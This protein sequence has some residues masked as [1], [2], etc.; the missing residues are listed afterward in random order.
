MIKVVFLFVLIFQGTFLFS[1]EGKTL[2]ATRISNAPNIDGLLNDA[3]WESLPYFGNFNMLK[4]GTDGDIPI[5]YE[6]KVQVAYDDTGLY[7]AAYMNDPFPEKIASQFSQRDDLSAQADF[8]AVTLNTYNDGINET[9]FGVTSSGTIF[10]SK[11]SINDEDLG[12]NVVF[13]GKTSRDDKGWYAEFK[14]PYNALRFPEVDI[15]NWSINFY[16]RIINT[17]ETHS[18]API[19]NTKGRSTIYN[20]PLVGVKDINPPVRLTLFPFAQGVVSS[21]EGDTSSNF[22]AGMDLKYGLSDS[23]T[24]DATLV[25]D[26]G[27]AAF[28]EVTLN[29]GPFEQTFDEQRQFFIEGTEL[30]NKGRIFFSRRVGGAPSETEIDLDENEVVTILP[31]SV[32]LLNAIKVSGRTKDNLGVGF[33]NVITEKTTASVKNEETGSIRNVLVEPLTNYSI[34]VLDQQFNNN[35]S[36]SLVN[37]NVTREGQFR[38]AN[39]T[40]LVFDL[41][42]KENAFK[43]SGRAI[44]SNVDLDTGIRTGFLSELELARIKGRFRYRVEHKFANTTYDIN[45]LGLNRRNNFNNLEAEVSFQSFEP[46]KIFNAY[47]FELS[48]RH[49]RLFDPNVTTGDSFKLETFFLLKSRIEFGG[50]IDYRTDSDNYFEPRLEGKFVTFSKNLG[51]RVFASSD[52]RKQFAIDLGIGQRKDFDQPQRQLFIDFSP[53]FRFSDK[54]ILLLDSEYSR[55]DNQFGYI[56]NTETEVFFGQR[57]LNSIENALTASYNFD[58]YKA[59]NLRFRNFWTAVDYSDDLFFK[60]NDDGTKDLIDY[61]I[62][63]ENDP[64]RNFNIWNLDLS[65]RWRF[66]PGSE[67][68][69]L[70]RNQIFNSDNQASLGYT[71]SLNKLF[72]QSMQNTVSLRIMYFIDYNNARDLFTKNR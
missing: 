41:T 35:S 71:E 1:Q 4:P 32:D 54:F 59:I 47:K 55:R 38:D 28:D 69:L 20:A 24:L 57:D 33:F 63:E 5:G 40:A 14:I 22:S 44:V 62:T 52:Y 61:K 15:Q 39:V 64:N 51:G 29:L 68:S 19:D 27:Q 17:N 67:V 10:D 23:F 56:D 45:D 72:S 70:Y 65:F 11:I 49:R 21:F 2:N 30:F 50:F 60:L 25:P 31:E 46:T 8:I 58:P 26:F 12:Y 53:R 3:I 37:T 34:L 18:F 48:A 66:A 43:A 42:D 36:I 16:R 7:I 6:T 13:Q 9:R